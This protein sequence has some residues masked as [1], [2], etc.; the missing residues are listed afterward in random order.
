MT[1]EEGDAAGFIKRNALR[2]C[3]LAQRKK[4]LGL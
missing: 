4:K 1:F 3:T 2:L